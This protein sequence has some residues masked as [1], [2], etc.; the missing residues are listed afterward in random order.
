M[1]RV[2]ARFT[3]LPICKKTAK[4]VSVSKRERAGEKERKNL[5]KT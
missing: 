1:R 2:E 5:Y 3:G 4:S